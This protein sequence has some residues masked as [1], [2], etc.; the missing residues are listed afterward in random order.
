MTRI[1]VVRHGQSLLNAAERMQG[2]SDAPL[3]PAGQEQAAARGRDFAAAGVRF[4][5][6]FSGDGIRHR[7]TAAGLLD[8]AGSDLRA[9]ADPRWR[10]LC[11][12]RLEAIPVRKFFR[13][14]QAYATAERPFI[15]TLEALAETDP[16]AESPAQVAARALE[17]LH[18]VAGAGSEVLVVTSGITIMSLMQ[19]LGADLA[20]LK[21]GP[22]NLSVSTVHRHDDG[23]RIERVADP[24]PFA[25]AA[26][27]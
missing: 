26:V 15:A 25:R 1:W 16:L 7:E 27:L 9:L 17:A 24:D 14:T 18:D 23:W 11:F 3:T 20:H 12:G 2:W 4:D 13:L 10:E 5:A 21:T 22:A 8:A 19:I 6:A